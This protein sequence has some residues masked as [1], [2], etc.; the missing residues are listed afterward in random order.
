MLIYIV[1]APPASDNVV[2]RRFTIEMQGIDPV[3]QTFGPQ[4]TALGQVA[5]PEGAEVTLT[6]VDVDDAGDVAETFGAVFV[7][8]S[9]GEVSDYFVTLSLS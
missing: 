1:T 5:A 7:A 6:L 4:D 2:E 9:E 3:T 8:A